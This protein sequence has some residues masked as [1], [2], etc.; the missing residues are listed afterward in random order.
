MAI[1]FDEDSLEEYMR[2]AVDASPEH[3]I[4][5]DQ[6]LEDAF[7]LDVDAISDGDDVVIGAIG[8]SGATA[9]QDEACAQ[10]GIDAVADLLK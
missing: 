5:I 6:F 9:D 1:V 4:L 10:A 2:E 8:V 3:P 7:E